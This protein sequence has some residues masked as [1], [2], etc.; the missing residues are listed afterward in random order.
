MYI[1]EIII[2]GFKS[3]AHRTVVGPFDSEFNAITGLNGS[4]K[5]NILDA[6]CFVLGISVLSQVRVNSLQELIYKQGQAG[7]TKASV[8]IVF[9]NR[10]KRP[11][12]CPVGYDQDELTVTRQTIVG[13]RNKYLIN[14][15]LAQHNAVQALFHS[16]QLNVNNPHFLIM[17]GR[18]TK[19]LN[20]KPAEILGLME[21][22][23]GTRMF[24]MKKVQARKTIEKKERK[25]VE[26]NQVMQEEIQPKLERLQKQRQ[27]YELF[28]KNKAELNKLQRWVVAATY[29][30]NLTSA[31]TARDKLKQNEKRVEDSR[32]R[33]GTC[34][35]DQKRLQE[36]IKGLRE[37]LAKEKQVRTMELE[38]KERALGNQVV[39]ASTVLENR[40]KEVSSDAQQVTETAGAIAE[41]KKNL[42]A[43]QKERDHAQ[44]AFDAASEKIEKLSRQLVNSQKQVELLKSGVAAGDDGQSLTEALMEW[45]RKATQA[46]AELK[47]SGLRVAHLQKALKEKQA[48]AGTQDAQYAQLQARLQALQPELDA[49][50]AA[51]QA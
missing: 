15:R 36:E 39:L 32:E 5:S 48:A 40:Q 38:K 12:Q 20:M 22:A 23:A 16:V 13:G 10:D 2:E 34:A 18:I 29:S 7:V 1:K 37:K 25:L 28:F 4:G 47:S 41:L 46:K 51:A 44:S 17:Q 30:R 19:V 21:E 6:I 27:D 26:I 33:L 50:Q 42:T 24:E 14:G 8:T 3:Y 45:T 49:L 9:D 43:K 11:G 35:V 31:D